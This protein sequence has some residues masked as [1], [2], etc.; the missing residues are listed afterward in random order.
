MTRKHRLFTHIHTY[1]NPIYT[2]YKKIYLREN[3][4]VYENYVK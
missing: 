3:K 4:K 1:T 2:L